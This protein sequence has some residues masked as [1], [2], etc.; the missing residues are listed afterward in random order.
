MV[1]AHGPTESHR[2]SHI[3]N[4]WMAELDTRR[5]HEVEECPKVKTFGMSEFYECPSRDSGMATESRTLQTVA[6]SVKMLETIREMDGARVSELSEA[7]GLAPSTIHAHLATLREQQL[8]VKEGDLY[9]LSLQ[10]LQV[11][12]YTQHRTEARKLADEYTR[13][14]VDETGYRA[15]FMVEE[16]GQGVFLHM[17]SGDHPPWTHTAAGQRSPLHPLAAGKAILSDYPDPVVREILEEQGM[18]AQTE[19]TITDLDEFFDELDQVR[20]DGYAFNDCENVQGIRAIG[21]PA[22]GP[23]GNVVGSFSISGPRH[24]MSDEMFREELPRELKSIVDE[25]ELELS[26]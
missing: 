2:N 5:K 24:S 19:N 21:A 22:R 17:C 3:S 25:Y 14:L 15:I 8:V 7:C 26:L 20:E 18:P 4:R 12:K 16:H 11:G 9:Q 13:K 1:V 10:F 23:D 6:R